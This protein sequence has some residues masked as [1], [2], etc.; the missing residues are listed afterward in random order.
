M[1]DS[2]SSGFRL[3]HTM[4]RVVDLEAS[5]KFYWAPRK[6]APDLGSVDIQGSQER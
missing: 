6:I 5:L 3:A 1:S 4:I 2:L